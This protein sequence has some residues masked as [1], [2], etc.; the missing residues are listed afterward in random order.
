MADRNDTRLLEVPQMPPACKES[1]LSTRS[2]HAVK[3]QHH[4]PRDSSRDINTST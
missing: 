2:Y 3:R 4:N 1:C